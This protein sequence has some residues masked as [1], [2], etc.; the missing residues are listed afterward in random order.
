MRS[1]RAPVY[2]GSRVCFGQRHL[3]VFLTRPAR[4]ARPGASS[5]EEPGVPNPVA[6]TEEVK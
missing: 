4:G 2:C 6:R 3:L 5:P 1:L